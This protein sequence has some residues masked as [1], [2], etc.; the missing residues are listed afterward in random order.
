MSADNLLLDQLALSLGETIRDAFVTSVRDFVSG[1][2]EDLQKYGSAMARH[3]VIAIARGDLALGREVK[4]QALLLL[5]INR[6]RVAKKHEATLVKIA[7]AIL[8][9]A[10]RAAGI[11][12]LTLIP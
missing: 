7:D 3:A 12:A 1:A 5:E 9:Y 10:V 4:H 11:A 6:L 8:S 2:E